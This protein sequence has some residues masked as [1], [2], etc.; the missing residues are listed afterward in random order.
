LRARKAIR[1][2]GVAYGVCEVPAVPYEEH[3][4][5][6]DAIVTERET[7]VVRRG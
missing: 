1:A 4:Q 6:L 3:D 5:S 2:V 7:I